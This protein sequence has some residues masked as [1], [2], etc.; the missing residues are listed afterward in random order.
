MDGWLMALVETVRSHSVADA[1]SGRGLLL[2]LLHR[3][4]RLLLL[5]PN[6]LLLWRRLGWRTLGLLLLGGS[7]VHQGR[8]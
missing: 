4:L 8:N 5:R 6:L 2:L 7:V 3:R 1:P